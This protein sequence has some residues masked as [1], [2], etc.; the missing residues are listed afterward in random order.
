MKI[1]AVRADVLEKI[2]RYAIDTE[3][4]QTTALALGRLIDTSPEVSPQGI[5]KQLEESSQ[6]AQAWV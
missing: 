1:I 6:D 5:E 3:F 2:R 4:A